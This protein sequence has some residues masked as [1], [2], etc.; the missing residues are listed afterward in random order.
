MTTA[1]RPPLRPLGSTGPAVFPLALGCMGMSGLY[2]PADRSESL[3]TLNAAL[4]AGITLLDTG[5]YYGM[6]DNELLLGEALRGWARERVVLSVKFGALRD[7]AGGWTGVDARPAAVKNFLAYTLRRLGTDY[8]DIYRPGRVDPN[9]PIEETV[10][11]IAEMVKAGHVRHIGLSEAGVATMRRAYAVH[12][13]C[14][15]QIEYSLLSRGIENGILPA[16]RQLGI[17][18]TIYG[19]LSR[20][21]LAGS[22]PAAAGDF[23]A[24]LPRFSGEN[25]DRNQRLVEA[26]GRLATEMNVRPAQLAIVWVLAKGTDIVPVVGARTRAQLAESLGALAVQLSPTDLARLE[27]AVPASAVA[28]TRYDERQMRI[29]DSERR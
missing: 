15:L 17:G 29:L 1:A 19:A 18:I 12:P 14:D 6:G 10:G 25:R 26:L 3:A 24:H 20:G 5:D 22:K 23:R 9:V 27:E 28:G 8:V 11:A 2:G 7:P 21:L 16:A 4:D 13:V